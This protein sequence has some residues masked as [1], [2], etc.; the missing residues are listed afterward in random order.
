MKSRNLSEQNCFN[1][2]ALASS[3]N[4][5]EVTI[6]KTYFASIINPICCAPTPDLTTVNILLAFGNFFS[7]FLHSFRLPLSSLM[8]LDCITVFSPCSF[9]IRY[10]FS[11]VFYVAFDFLFVADSFE[12]VQGFLFFFCRFDFWVCWWHFEQGYEC[13]QV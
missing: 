1:L 2:F 7:Y 5:K 10:R 4:V 13:W 9:V 6:L 11:S 3:K 8:F 12:S